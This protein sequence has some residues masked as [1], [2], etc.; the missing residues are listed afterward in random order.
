MNDFKTSQISIDDDIRCM[1]ST[2]DDI[3]PSYHYRF[4][5]CFN[6]IF[7][8]RCRDNFYRVL[9]NFYPHRIPYTFNSEPVVP[10]RWRKFWCF[11]CTDDFFNAKRC[12]FT[13][14]TYLLDRF[15]DAMFGFQPVL[16]DF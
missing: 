7:I 14:C 13:Y 15:K 4:Y 8:T 5:V 9:G 12:F 2:V 6:I 16:G 11:T 10:Y 1:M 3:M